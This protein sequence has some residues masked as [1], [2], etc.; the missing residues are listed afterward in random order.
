MQNLK[1]G[2]PLCQTRQNYSSN[3]SQAHKKIK[4][5]FQINDNAQKDRSWKSFLKPKFDT[6]L[7][8]KIF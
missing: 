4:S 2:A 6:R 3:N 7:F 1:N 5:V 8:V